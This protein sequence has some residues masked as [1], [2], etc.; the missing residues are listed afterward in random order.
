[1]IKMTMPELLKRAAFRYP[2]KEAI[3]SEKGRWTYEQWEKNANKRAR[4]LSKYGI[5]RGDHVATLFL[6]GSEVLETFLALMKLG[7]VI[8]PLNVRLSGSELHYIVEHSDATSQNLKDGWFLNL[9]I[10][11]HC[12]SSSLLSTLIIPGE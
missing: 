10:I 9:R 3:V 1:M 2:Q 12:L 8:V 11:F 5:K 7:A 6:N 4:A